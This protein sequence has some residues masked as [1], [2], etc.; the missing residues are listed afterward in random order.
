[1]KYLFFFSALFFLI[2]CKEEQEEQDAANRFF[3]A[4]KLNELNIDSLTEF[5]GAEELRIYASPFKNRSGYVNGV[6]YENSVKIGRA[7]V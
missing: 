5:F 2:G 3:S 7:H 1:M 4:D 6:G